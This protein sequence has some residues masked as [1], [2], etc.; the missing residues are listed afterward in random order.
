MWFLYH[1]KAQLWFVISGLLALR[2][3]SWRGLQWVGTKIWGWRKT[4]TVALVVAIASLVVAS[5]NALVNPANSWFRQYVWPRVDI[6]AISRDLSIDDQ[7]TFQVAVNTLPAKDQYR[8]TWTLSPVRPGDEKLMGAARQDNCDPPPLRNF[9]TAFE[10][11]EQQRSIG[12]AVRVTRA[13]GKNMGHDSVDIVLHNSTRPVIGIAPS[14]GIVRLGGTAQLVTYFGPQKSAATAP[15]R[16]SWTIGGNAI[17]SQDCSISYKAEARPDS[18]A[19]Q[20]IDVR[21]LLSD[22]AGIVVG[23][24]TRKFSVVWPTGDFYMYA[25]ETTDR[26]NS[27]VRGLTLV[28]SVADLERSIREKSL[29]TA[30]VGIKA[31]G[32]AEP[33]SDHTKCGQI[34]NLYD[35]APIDQTILEEKLSGIKV[36]GFLAPVLRTAA[37]SMEELTKHA[38]HNVW[39]YLVMIT[40]GPDGCPST[41]DDQETLK[42]L[43]A[44]IQTAALQVGSIEFEVLGLT[45]RLTTTEDA[46][47][48]IERIWN[49]APA[50]GNIPYFELVVT[51]AGVLNR[52]FDAVAGLANDSRER[53]RESCLTLVNLLRQEPDLTPNMRE[54]PNPQVRQMDEWCRRP[55]I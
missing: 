17:E 3:L 32:R 12:V 2:S 51:S 14:D 31:F 30:S 16:C 23:E 24:A 42:Q 1:L 52:A 13:D 10:S 15:Y 29:V 37:V 6:T 26:M 5:Y 27:R 4:V 7:T 53:R 49:S 38:Q 8:C 33:Q 55:R 40:G 47:L 41:P 46:P 11:N 19:Q 28:S 18:P 50:R 22:S 25:I 36:N 34:D 48:V 54:R 35:L 20:A 39:L 21:V 43:A 45:L 44:T 9:G